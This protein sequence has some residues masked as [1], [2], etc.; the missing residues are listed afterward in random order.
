MVQDVDR[1]V[2]DRAGLDDGT[3]AAADAGLFVGREQ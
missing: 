3:T 1:V 2:P